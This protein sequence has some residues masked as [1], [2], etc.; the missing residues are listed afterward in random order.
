MTFEETAILL[1]SIVT[2][3]PNAR[4]EKTKDTVIAWHK[5]M[6]DCDAPQVEDK[7]LAYVKAGNHFPPT[8]ADLYI[9]KAAYRPEHDREK[10]LA[11]LNMIRYESETADRLTPEQKEEVDRVKRDIERILFENQPNV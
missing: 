6:D 1:N 11:H 5:V 3:Y 8:P 2:Y 10:T 9:K 7:L 4:I